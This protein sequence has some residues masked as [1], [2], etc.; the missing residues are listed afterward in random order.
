[1]IV[2]G[3]GSKH[4]AT[5]HLESEECP[6]C[7]NSALTLH[8]YHKYFDVFWIPVFPLSKV[9]VIDCSHCKLVMENREI[10]ESL[11]QV[12][13]QEKQE[14]STPFYLF[15][16]SFLVLLA[17]AFAIYSGRQEDEQTQ[18]YLSEPQV[19][20]YYVMEMFNPEDPTYKYAVC[21]LNR[22]TQDSLEVII[23]QYV[24]QRSYYAKDAINDGEVN[25]ADYF[26]DTVKT[27]RSDIDLNRVEAVVRL[28]QED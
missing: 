10:P 1:M 9:A 28:F 18:A 21:K 16:G 19:N 27:A 3:T 4:L 15:A 23:G 6:S 17:I 11:Q 12:I 25:N 2:F 26:G 8:V 5:K 20:D 22:L 13:R 7:N 24:Y 14:H